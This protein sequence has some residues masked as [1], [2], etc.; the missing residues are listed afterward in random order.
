MIRTPLRLLAVALCAAGLAACSGTGGTAPA[1]PT[2]APVPAVPGTPAGTAAR[3]PAIPSPAGHG[4]LAGRVVVLDPGHN[5]GNFAH[6]SVIDRPVDAGGFQKACNT[7]GTSARG[8]TESSVNLQVADLLAE[9]LRSRGARVA[10]TRDDDTGVGPCIDERGLLAQ[11]EAADVLVSI[12]ADGASAG[13]HG[14]H[15]IAPGPVPGYTDGIVEPSHRLA[16]D[17]R[18]ALSGQGLSTSTYAGSDGLV[19]RT[20][21]GTLNRAGVPAVMVELG[22]MHNGDD[23]ARLTGADGQARYADGLAAGIAGYLG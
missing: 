18:D 9:R 4:S 3:P 8:V 15:V 22:N 1:G 11:L 19:T 12:H 7:T 5:G 14:F 17:V 2:G 13:Q 21:L 6:P 23:F 16:A 20:D 10:L